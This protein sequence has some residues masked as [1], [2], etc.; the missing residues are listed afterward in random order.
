KARS[1]SAVTGSRSFLYRFVLALSRGDWNHVCSLL[2][3]EKEQAGRGWRGSRGLMGN[4]SVPVIAWP[5][6]VSNPISLTTKAP[7]FPEGSEPERRK[8]LVSCWKPFARSINH[9]PRR[10]SAES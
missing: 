10:S 5:Q 3:V 1:D 9:L 6:E 7:E 4:G 8:R 2:L